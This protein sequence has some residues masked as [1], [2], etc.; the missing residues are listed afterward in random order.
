MALGVMADEPSVTILDDGIYYGGYIPEAISANGIYLSGSTY[1]YA[2]FVSEWQKQA[3]T[4]LLDDSGSSY[5]DYGCD[6]P[7]ISNSGV[8]LGFDDMGSFK[9]NTLTKELERLTLADRSAGIREGLP[10]QMTEDGSIIVGLAYLREPVESDFIGDHKI[11]TQAAYWEN[12]KAH[13]LPVPS[14]EELG[15]YILG[16]RARCISSDGSVIMGELIDRLYTNPMVLWIRQDD[17]S[18]KLDAVCMK[19]FSDIKYNDGS[20]KKYVQFRGDA[21]N[22]CGTLIAMTVREA[23]EYGKEAVAPRRLALYDIATEKITEA[24]INPEEGIEDDTYLE[25]YYNGISDNGTITGYYENST[26]GISGFIMYPDDMLTRNIMNVFET[27]GELADFEDTGVNKISS[28]S[29][30]ARYIAGVSWAVNKTYD[31]GYYLGYV[32]DTGESHPVDPKPENPENPDSAVESIMTDNP[33]GNPE[34]LTPSGLR[35]KSP[36]KGINIVRY[37]D[38]TTR[39]EIIR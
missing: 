22:S 25:V 11:D 28:I 29:A 24:L 3:T 36:S 18:Y 10:A 4:V 39:K 15:Y 37:P 16:S 38:G 30:D 7:F 13:L 12:G 6:L 33:A 17:G 21:M 31:V 20:Y 5:L 34:Y 1:I 35:L 26:G 14:E 19:Y 32:L 8:A 27:L 23:P 9:Y 2:G